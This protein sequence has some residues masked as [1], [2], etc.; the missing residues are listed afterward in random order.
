MNARLAEVAGWAPEPRPLRMTPE[1]W[2]A[3]QCWAVFL[4]L[5]GPRP[6]A[7]LAQTALLTMARPEVVWQLR[8]NAGNEF[9]A[10]AVG[11]RRSEEQ[12]PPDERWASEL[13]HWLATAPQVSGGIWGMADESTTGSNSWAVAGSRTDS[14]RPLLA[15]D[16]HRAFTGPNVFYQVHL[17]AEGDGGFDAIGTAFPGMPGI[18]YYGHN[19]SVAWCVTNGQADDCDF[20]VERFDSTG[21]YLF[22]PGPEW[23]LR[24][25]SNASTYGKLRPS[26]SRSSEP[27]RGVAGRR[28][29]SARGHRRPMDS[30]GG[31]GHDA[32]VPLAHARC[33]ERS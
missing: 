22:V 27:P 8:P 24:F 28:P 6:Q 25:G 31:H 10:Q 18:P 13:R 15:G 11:T 23:I 2:E 14:G 5:N 20:F 29:R 16:P 30:T 33:P 1:P 19:T 21:R 4:Y 26:Q 17:A 7:K 3:W 9:V 32:S 12:D